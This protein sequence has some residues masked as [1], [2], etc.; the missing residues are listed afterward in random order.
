MERLPSD[1]ARLWLAPHV[2]CCAIDRQVV[3]LDLLQSRY[4]AVAASPR[5]SA[6]VRGW[7]PCPE[8]TASDGRRDARLLQSLREQGLVG[9]RPLPTLPTPNHVPPCRSIALEPA[10]GVRGL[11]LPATL[12]I[13]RAAAIARWQL[14]HRNLAAISGDVQDRRQRISTTRRDLSIDQLAAVYHR[15]RPLLYTARDQCLLDSLALQRF[16]ADTGHDSTWVIGI[17]AR[18]FAAHSWLQSEDAVLNDH[19]ERVRR[20]RPILVV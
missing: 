7:P 5:L 12:R 4:L 9:E 2:R 20:F 13:M 6:S 14:R 15:L 18:P 16:L 8:A 3:L 11:G 10:P 1:A 17:R 19:H